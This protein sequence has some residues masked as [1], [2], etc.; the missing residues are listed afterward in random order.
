MEFSNKGFAPI[1]FSHYR[2][3]SGIMGQKGVSHPP[4]SAIIT[5]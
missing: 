5:L 1:H 3:S 2:L 4:N